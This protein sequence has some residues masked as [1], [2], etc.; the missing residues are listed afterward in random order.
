MYSK[1]FQISYEVMW[2]ESKMCW[3]DPDGEH[4]ALETR[5]FGFLHWNCVYIFRT[6]GRRSNESIE[7][8]PLHLQ[9][10]PKG[11]LR[12]MPRVRSDEIHETSADHH[13]QHAPNTQQVQHAQHTQHA[14]AHAHAH[15]KDKTPSPIGAG[16]P[17]LQRLRLLKEK[18]VSL[19]SYFHLIQ[20]FLSLWI[21]SLKCFVYFGKFQTKSSFNNGTSF[22]MDMKFVWKKNS[23]YLNFISMKWSVCFVLWMN[24]FKRFFFSSFSSSSFI[25]F[26]IYRLNLSKS[27][28]D[29]WS[30]HDDGMIFRRKQVFVNL[31]FQM[32]FLQN[33]F[34]W[35]MNF[36]F[37]Y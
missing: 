30:S 12:R 32:I 18:Q 27:S 14:H 5:Y 7:L 10:G 1:I 22:V 20:F 26:S 23:F 17:L 8:Q 19:N 37:T 3:K 15:E 21:F 13:V 11:V 24:H 29:L 2:K 28:F 25:V 31:F 33:L 36:I 6:T 16:L 9:K 34:W 4:Q 35:T